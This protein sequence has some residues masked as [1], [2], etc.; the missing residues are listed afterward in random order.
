ML[1]KLTGRKNYNGAWN[2]IM[3]FNSVYNDHKPV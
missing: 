3:N 2:S 1:G